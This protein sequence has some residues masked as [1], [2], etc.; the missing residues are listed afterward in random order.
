M[1]VGGD[2]W[3]PASMLLFG[4]RWLLLLPLLLLVPPAAFYDR[5]LLIP[6]LL[7]ALIISGPLM[8]INLPIS[9]IT[10]SVHSGSRKLRVLTCNIDGKF[11]DKAL[12][13]ST[14]SKLSVDIVAL[15]ECPDDI[16][17]NLPVGWQMI[18]E[19]GLAVISKFPLRKVDTVKI[20]KPGGQWPGTYLL[21][22]AV[23]AP[24]GDIAVCSILLPTPRVGLM[25]ILDRHTIVRPSRS[26]FFYEETGFRR[27]AA[28]EVRR[29]VEQISLPVIVVGDFNTPVEST[30]Y[31]SVWSA[32]KNAFSEI[33]S[34]YGWTQRV[35]VRS[36]SYSSRIDH[37]LTGKGL[38]PLLC[39]VGT[40][41]GSD[42][43]PLIADLA[44]DDA[45]KR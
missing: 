13:A 42:H 5:R 19:R 28:L 26:R 36:L 24:G 4:P 10:G 25:T 37:I 6:L 33:G 21:H 11:S 17:L 38:T 34:G 39:E 41:I 45:V 8:H 20:T 32:F 2:R 22:A 7:S 27:S 15:Q 30:I 1:Y 43:L 35:S 23:Q 9:K 18:T 31:R 44:V 14:I 16:K 29:Y 12:L 40:D 3:W